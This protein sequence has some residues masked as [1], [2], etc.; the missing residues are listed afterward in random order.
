MDVHDPATSSSNVREVEE[1]HLYVA[2]DLRLTVTGDALYDDASMNSGE[3]I[4]THDAGYNT[5]I[6]EVDECNSFGG[7]VTIPAGDTRTGCVVF[8]VPDDRGPRSFQFSLDSGLRAADRRMGVVAGRVRPR[9]VRRLSAALSASG[10][11]G[12]VLF[13]RSLTPLRVRFGGRAPL[14]LQADTTRRL[15][16]PQMPRYAAAASVHPP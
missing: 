13:L 12:H 16:A 9:P 2:A 8:E 15:P 7:G 14:R 11:L 3:L 6:A 5:T 4:D 10:G 1:R